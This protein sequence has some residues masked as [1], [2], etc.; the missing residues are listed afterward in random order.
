MLVVIGQHVREL[1]PLATAGGAHV[2]ALSEP[3]PD[4]RSTV[5]H[6]LRWIEERYQPQP[7]DPWLLVPADHPVLDPA[8]VRQVLAAGT[9][10]RPIVVPAHKGRRGHPTRFAWRHAA[11]IH[12]LP[13]DQGINALLGP[14]RTRC[15]NCPSVMRW[16]CAISTH[17]TTTPDSWPGVLIILS[18]T[19]P[20]NL[21]LSRPYLH[22]LS[23][24]T[25]C[26]PFVG[27][28]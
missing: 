23:G 19:S 4:M 17:P 18:R 11:A 7:N 15:V 14:T 26:V 10:A 12:G 22:Q 24:G 2:L 20:H 27:W 9:D 8:L 28:P 5:E 21:P 6:G 3:T 25:S 13:E 1:A 16:S